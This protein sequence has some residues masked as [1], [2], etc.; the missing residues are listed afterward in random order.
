[1]SGRSTLALDSGMLFVFQ[2]EALWTFWMK[3]TLIPLDILFLDSRFEIVDIQTMTPQPGVRDFDLRRYNPQSP[4]LYA[5]EINA[6]RANELG[7]E[8]GMGMEVEF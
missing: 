4:S 5:V 7:I 2:S 6:G 8:V 3:D 1:M